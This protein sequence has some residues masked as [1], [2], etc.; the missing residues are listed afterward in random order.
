MKNAVRL[1]I[2]DAAFRDDV[3]LVFN[4]YIDPAV[5]F[6]RNRPDVLLEKCERASGQLVDYPWAVG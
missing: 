2:G 5:A 6:Q 1:A 3:E 4:H